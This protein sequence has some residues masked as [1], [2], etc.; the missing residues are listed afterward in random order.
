MIVLYNKVDH[1]VLATGISCVVGGLQRQLEEHDSYLGFIESDEV[2]VDAPSKLVITD[3]FNRET[4]SDMLFAAKSNLSPVEL[5]E[6]SRCVNSST[7]PWFY[8]QYAADR[9][10]FDAY[11]G[12]P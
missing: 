6:F 7:S 10:L 5:A 12:L 11:V 4:I 2:L 1:K 9:E 3:N 8:V